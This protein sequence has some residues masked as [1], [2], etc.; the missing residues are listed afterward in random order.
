[1]NGLYIVASPP[2]TVGGYRLGGQHGFLFLLR[3]KPRWLHRLGVRL[4]LG[5]VWEDAR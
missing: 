1:M 3:D 2:K 4:V 5:W